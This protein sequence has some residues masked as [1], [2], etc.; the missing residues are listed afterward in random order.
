MLL[1]VKIC[2]FEFYLGKTVNI[3]RTRFN[4]HRGSIN[5]MNQLCLYISDI[6]DKH[7]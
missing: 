5:I 3:A 6:Y 7:I 4:G 1:F 2:K